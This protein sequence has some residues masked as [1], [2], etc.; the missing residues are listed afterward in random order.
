MHGAFA[1]GGPFVVYVTGRDLADK[2]TFRATI[3]TLWALLG[4]VLCATYAL[5]GSLGASSLA[6]SA[7]LAL[8]AAT[9]LVLGEWLHARAQAQ[10]FRTA[11]FGMLLVAG[12]LLAIR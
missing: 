9:G 1:T 11:L 5:D 2:A 12:V 7:V 10:T 6:A 3:S 4:M 8:P